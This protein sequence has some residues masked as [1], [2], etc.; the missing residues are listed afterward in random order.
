MKKLNKNKIYQ[1]IG[2]ATIVI[3][4]NAGMTAMFVAGFMQNTIY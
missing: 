2:Q 3:L 4:F 1:F